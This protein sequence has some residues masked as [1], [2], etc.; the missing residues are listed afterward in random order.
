MKPGKTTLRAISCVA[1]AAIALLALA[2]CPNPVA[3]M[4]K[5]EGWGLLG[6]WVSNRTADYSPGVFHKLTVNANG[7]FRSENDTGSMS[8]EGTYVVDSVTV[9]G[10]AR[11]FMIDFTYGIPPT[12]SH[13]YVLARVTDGTTYENASTTFLPYPSVIPPPG[14]PMYFSATLQ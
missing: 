1:I 12:Y 7:T 5:S 8:S 13:N 14:D 10:N 3:D 11:T 6:T 4:L 9:S 2:S